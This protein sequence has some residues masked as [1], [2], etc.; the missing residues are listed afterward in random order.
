[1]TTPQKRSKSKPKSRYLIAWFYGTPDIPFVMAIDNKESAEPAA[2]IRNAV[3]IEIRQ[4]AGIRAFDWYFRDDVGRPMPFNWHK[5]QDAPRGWKVKYLVLWWE[6]G[7]SVKFPQ[8]IVT[9]DSTSAHAL[10][11]KYSGLLFEIFKRELRIGETLDYRFYRTEGQAEQMEWREQSPSI[12][13]PWSGMPVL[14][15]RSRV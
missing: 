12:L 13:L 5:Y 8:A 6:G 10:A 1:M 14:G 9:Y 4:D 15:G 7:G 11:V 2:N 3:M